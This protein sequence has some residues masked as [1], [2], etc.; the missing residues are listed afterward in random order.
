MEGD[1]TI[2]L[3]S[4]DWFTKV[5]TVDLDS[6]TSS[7]E[8][9]PGTLGMPVGVHWYAAPAAFDRTARLWRLGSQMLARGHHDV[10]LPTELAH[11]LGAPDVVPIHDFRI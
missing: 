1:R 2:A 8:Y 4:V 6:G 11:E 5:T 10:H 9:Q 3:V 7:V